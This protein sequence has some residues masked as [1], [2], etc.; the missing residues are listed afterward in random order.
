MAKKKS[1]SGKKAKTSDTDTGGSSGSEQAINPGKPIPR[2]PSKAF[3]II[4][5]GASAGGLA[6]LKQFFGLIP[7]DTG[8]AFV[9]VVHLSPDHESHLAELLQPY[10]NMP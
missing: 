5:I 10:V 7:K 4:G 2:D 6:A 3:P 8:F 9:V 1:D